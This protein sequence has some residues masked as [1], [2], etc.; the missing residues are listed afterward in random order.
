MSR[1]GNN[2]VGDSSDEVGFGSFFI[3]RRTMEEIYSGD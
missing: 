1:D 3:F 2:R